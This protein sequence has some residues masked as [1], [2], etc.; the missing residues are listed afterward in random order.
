MIKESDIPGASAKLDI[1][2]HTIDKLD[3][4]DYEYIGMD[5]FALPHDDLVIARQNGT[6]Q[7]NFQGYSTHADCDLIGLGVSAIGRIGDA[8]AQ[9]ASTTAEYQSLLSAGRLPVTR[10]IEVDEDDRLRAAVIQH[11]MCQDAVNV[12]EFEEEHGICFSTYFRD[13]LDKLAP[14]AADGLVEIDE[15]TIEVT[16]KGRLLVRNVAMAFDRH[17]DAH[18]DTSRFS[19][20][21]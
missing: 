15:R 11:L 1:L 19:R 21:I 5:H 12:G 16:A 8:Y 14:L 3:A 18:T 13:E 2:H 20:A 6:L 9:N 10:G 17:L 4:S 7:R